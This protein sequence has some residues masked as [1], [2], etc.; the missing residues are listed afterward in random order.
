VLDYDKYYVNKL[1]NPL[2][3]TNFNGTDIPAPPLSIEKIREV[4][5]FYNNETYN[6]IWIK[7]YG[8]CQTTQVGEC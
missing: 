6:E 5:W 7:N 1:Y 8:S 3:V 4:T 2:L